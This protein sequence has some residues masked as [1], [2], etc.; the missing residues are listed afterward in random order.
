MN[1]YAIVKHV[2][3]NP[4]GAIHNF[5][6]KPLPCVPRLNGS[7]AEQIG[8]TSLP[9]DPRFKPPF[10]FMK[11]LMVVVSCLHG[12]CRLEVRCRDLSFGNAISTFDV[13]RFLG[14]AP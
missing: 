4:F 6:L 11:Y 9:Q 10:Y 3:N 5:P 1:D 13:H 8:S 14:G 7:P 12:T 2:F